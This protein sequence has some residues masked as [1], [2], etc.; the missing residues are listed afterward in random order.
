MSYTN[1]ISDPLL[2]PLC[3]VVLGT[4]SFLRCRARCWDWWARNQ[5]VSSGGN[6][7]RDKTKRKLKK[8][9]CDMMNETRGTRQ[10]IRVE[11]QKTVGEKEKKRRRE[12][13]E[14]DCP[15]RNNAQH[16]QQYRPIYNADVL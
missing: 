1:V 6:L 15:A 8:E 16:Q 13:G 14:K 3:A 10:K 12:D 7:T 9:K 11:T 4:T 5:G 2:D